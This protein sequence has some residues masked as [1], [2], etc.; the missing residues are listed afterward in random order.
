MT[1]PSVTGK[2]LPL[3]AWGAFFGLLH[4]SSCSPKST[5]EQAGSAQSD[6]AAV[7]KETLMNLKKEAFGTTKEGTPVDLY[8]LSNGNGLT[9]KITNYGGIVTSVVTPD[10]NG[11]PGDVVLG[12]DSLSGYLKENPFFGALAGRY[13]NRIAKGRFQLDG[14]EYKLATNNGPNHLHGGTKGFDKQVWEAEEMGGGAG[15]RL[16][17]RSPDGE[18]GYPGNLTV[19]V[20]YRL[21]PE[22][23]LK[24]DYTAQTDKA[25]PLNLTNHSYFNLSAGKAT[26]ALTHE[27]MID[28]DKYT[29]VDATLIPTGELRPV[30]GTPMDFTGRQSAGRQSAEPDSVAPQLIGTHIAE[31]KGGYDHNYVLNHP[32]GQFSLAARA[33]EPVSGRVME[34]YTD[35]PGVQFYTGNFLNGS[36]T[37]KEGFKYTKHYGFCLE[38]QHFPDSP[39]QPAFPSAILKPGETYRTATEYRF[40]VRQ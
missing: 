26:G 37:G 10:K 27:L 17:Y 8:T 32:E 22:N 29:V 39:N 12:F 15:L 2:R 30:K 14:V 19:A 25:T 20:V 7:I 6:S 1:N 3:L 11:I 13:A 35:Q 23:G 18:E 33:Y 28:A 4:V 36:L 16:T 31:V 9:V 40:S 34:V 21:T 38:T 5:N 24:I